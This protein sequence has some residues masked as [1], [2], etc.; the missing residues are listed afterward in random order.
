MSGCRLSLLSKCFLC[1]PTLSVLTL[2]VFRPQFDVCRTIT[3]LQH[4]LAL[5]CV[6]LSEIPFLT[7]YFGSVLHLPHHMANSITGVKLP[8]E[9]V[10][11]HPPSSTPFFPIFPRAHFGIGFG[12]L[13]TL[14]QVL[15]AEEIFAP[16]RHS[17]KSPQLSLSQS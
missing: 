8:Y 14:T 7:L 3:Y 2:E 9:R 1:C 10:K 16:Q 6:T 17:Q 15:R 12:Q 5:Q 13:V 4:H 11:C